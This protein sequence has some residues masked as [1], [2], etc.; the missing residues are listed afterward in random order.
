[1]KFILPRVVLVL[2][3]IGAAI[4]AYMEAVYLGE[5]SRGLGREGGN[6]VLW[7]WVFRAITAALLIAAVYFVIAILRRLFNTA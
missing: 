7:A 3:F 1:M 6:V 2:I 4:F 5:Q